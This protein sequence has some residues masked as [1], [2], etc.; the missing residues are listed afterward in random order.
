MPSTSHCATATGP[1]RPPPPATPQWSH[2]HHHFP[3]DDV[4]DSQADFPPSGT[5]AGS[6][7]SSGSPWWGNPYG[8]CRPGRPSPA[9]INA[10]DH[11]LSQI[12]S[13]TST[14]SSNLT[15]DSY[16]ALAALP[17]SYPWSSLVLERISSL[18]SIGT[19]SLAS[20]LPPQRW[21]KTSNMTRPFSLF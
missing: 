14:L 3:T 11:L 5:Y 19:S 6:T 16:A 17:L 9:T 2:P 21:V 10:L 20:W 12:D 1:P 7:P 15:A 13:T 8:R 4:L 18:S